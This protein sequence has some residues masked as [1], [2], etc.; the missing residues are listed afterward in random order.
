MKKTISVLLL[1]SSFCFG[2]LFDQILFGGGDSLQNL[3]LKEGDCFSYKGKF[4][5]FSLDH[6]ENLGK[7]GIEYKHLAGKICPSHI[8]FKIDPRLN[9]FLAKDPKFGLSDEEISELSVSLKEV[10]AKVKEF[11]RSDAVREFKND[12]VFKKLKKNKLLESILNKHFKI[13][14]SHK[15]AVE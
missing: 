4:N 13:K 3:Q 1:L 7:I 11:E 12:K 14:P 10:K 6:S 15:V 8:A 2:G 5:I 9:D